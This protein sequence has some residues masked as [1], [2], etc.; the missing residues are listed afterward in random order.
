MEL[1][2]SSNTR[3]QVLSGLLSPTGMQRLSELGVICDA[4]VAVSLSFT[5]EGKG[6]KLLRGHLQATLKLPCN[7]CLEVTDW[8]LV[9]H[10]CLALVSSEDEAAEDFPSEVEPYVVQGDRLA[11]A[12][13]IEDEIILALP[14]L[15]AH[16][17]EQVCTL[18]QRYRQESQADPAEVGDEKPNPFA[19]LSALKQLN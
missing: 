2:L 13:V 6:L 3:S 8:P 11:L 17:D 15:V 9:S 7:R 4:D 1:D 18:F 14:A 19:V 10:F 12:D 16:E 5:N